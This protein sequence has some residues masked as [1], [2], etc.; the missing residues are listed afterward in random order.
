MILNG[1]EKNFG[2]DYKVLGAIANIKDEWSSGL[3]IGK[4]ADSRIETI[5]EFLSVSIGSKD[6]WLR[7]I[8]LSVLSNKKGLFFD[9]PYSSAQQSFSKA[10]QYILYSDP[11]MPAFTKAVEDFWGYEQVNDL[12]ADEFLCEELIIPIEVVMKIMNSVF[13]CRDIGGSLPSKKI[14]SFSVCDMLPKGLN[15]HV[16]REF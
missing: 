12:S 8:A 13:Y 1:I 2:F 4:R 16:N 11:T 6:F 5:A 9:L 3:F 14:K 7:I 15:L 10:C